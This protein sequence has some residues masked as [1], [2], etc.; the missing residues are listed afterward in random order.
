MAI[1]IMKLV[2]GV[3]SL[4]QFAEWQAHNRF[5]F[6]G[7]EA[8]IIFTRNKPKQ[9]EEIIANNGS[10]YR[11]IK[12]TMCCRQQIIG[13]EQIQTDAG[14]KCLIYTDTKIIRTQPVVRKAFQGWRYVPEGKTPRDIGP[15]MLGAEDSSGGL[16]AELMAAGVI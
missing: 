11:I 16:E 6:K 15:Y 2:V 14:P 7:K 5:E 3:D 4:A 13:F 1:H 12:G 8:N 9:A 10:A